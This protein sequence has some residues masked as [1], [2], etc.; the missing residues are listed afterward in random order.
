[1]TLY[2]QLNNRTETAVKPSLIKKF[3]QIFAGNGKLVFSFQ[4]NFGIYIA[5]E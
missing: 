5:A 3:I 1:M 4:N 2:P